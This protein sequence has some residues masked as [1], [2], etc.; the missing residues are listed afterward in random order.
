MADSVAACTR[1]VAITLPPVMLPATLKADAPVLAMATVVA[2]LKVTVPA[3]VVA[4][5]GPMAMVVVDPAKPP[6]P[7]L[8]VL[9]LPVPVAP[10][11][12]LAVCEAVL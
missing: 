9:V 6:T 3:A 5:T 1:V 7:I 10:V 4:V 8:M 2:V 12:M 11:A